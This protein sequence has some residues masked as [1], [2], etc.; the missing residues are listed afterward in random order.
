MKTCLTPTM[1]LISLLAIAPIP[2]VAD[3]PAGSAGVIS[4]EEQAIYE[5]VLGSWLGEDQGRH[6]VNQELS[7]APS[8]ANPGFADCAHGLRFRSDVPRGS[9]QQSLLG[10]HFSLQGIELVDGRKW[11]PADPGQAI[12]TGESVQTA[13]QEGFSGA[14]ISFSR[15]AFSQDG[16]E[17][18]VKF[19]MVCG[20]L[21]GTG[22]MV[23]LHKS[24]AGWSVLSHCGNWI[25]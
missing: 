20:S 6:L 1:A 2:S 14:L 9:S 12:S 13:V 7:A 25:S 23:H 8:S 24:A 5:S 19:S 21:C 17:A 18:L 11:K 4:Q 3:Q 10:V 15:I 22:S 16:K